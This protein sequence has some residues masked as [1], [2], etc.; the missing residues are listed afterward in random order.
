MVIVFYEE[1]I[2]SP[3]SVDNLE[4]LQIVETARL[5]GCRTY[6]LPAAKDNITVEL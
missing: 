1:S 6:L 4:I 5:Y 3:T 2:H